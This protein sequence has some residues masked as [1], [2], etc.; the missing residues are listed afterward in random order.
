MREVL[1]DLRPALTDDGIAVLVIGDVEMDRGKPS[2][3]GH[4]LAERVWEEAAF[5]A[6]LPACRPRARRGRR[7]S[8]DDPPVGRRTPAARRRPTASSSWARRRPAGAGRSPRPTSPSTGP[9]RRPGCA[10]CNVRP[11]FRG[12]H[13]TG[14]RPRRATITASAD[15]LPDPRRDPRHG[16]RAPHH[17]APPGRRGPARPARARAR[18]RPRAG[19]RRAAAAPGPRSPT[20]PTSCQTPMSRRSSRRSTPSR[21]PTTSSC[22]SRS[23]TRPA[24]RT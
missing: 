21:T 4:A 2:T 22:S 18:L 14:S 10:R 3:A 7:Q 23:S 9:G 15:D 24:W 12:L 16:A 6:G 8:Q 19:G 20:R 11:R 13:G 5:P 1:T 17:H